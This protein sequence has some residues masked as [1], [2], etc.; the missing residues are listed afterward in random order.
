M[1]HTGL[2]LDLP[3]AAVWT[4]KDGKALRSHGYMTKAEALKAAGLGD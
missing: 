3:W 4:I 2:D 1:R